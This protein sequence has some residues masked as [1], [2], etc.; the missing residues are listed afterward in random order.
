MA[1]NQKARNCLQGFD[2]APIRQKYSSRVPPSPI[3]RRVHNSHDLRNNHHD[4]ARNL[5]VQQMTVVSVYRRR[6]QPDTRA[7]RLMAILTLV[8]LSL[9][10]RVKANI[11]L[12]FS[13]SCAVLTDGSAKCWGSGSDGRLGRGG[14]TSSSFWS[15]STP[16]LVSELATVQSL[17]LGDF[18]SCAVLNDGSAKCWGKNSDGQL[19]D[20]TTTSSSTPVSV[21]GI[22][23]AVS[24][25]LGSYHSC[26]ILTDGSIKCWGKG[27]SLGGLLG[28]GATTSSSSPVSVSGI[29]TATSIALGDYFSC[30]VLTDGS[31]KCWG[32]NGYGQLGD[33]SSTHSSIPVSVSGI[34]TAT[35]ISLGSIH[36]CAVLTDR[37]IKCWGDNSDGRLGDGSTT[38][39]ATPVS[40]TGISTAVGVALGYSYSCAVLM[41]GSAKCWGTN[42]YGQ[43][44]D[45]STTGS[46]TPVSVTG[47]STASS[48]AL[49]SYHSCALLTDELAKCWGNND[50]GQLGDG[51]QTSSSTPVSVIDTCDA[52][53]APSNGGVGDCT[54]SLA[55]GSTCQ[56]T[57]NSGYTVSGTSSCSAG[58]LT[59]ATCAAT[60]VSTSASASYWNED[61]S[62]GSLKD[63][64]SITSSS[65]GTK[66]AAVGN[67][68]RIWTSTDFGE[69]W[70][71][72]SSMG[73][74]WW[75]SITSSSDG[76][77]LAA[78]ATSGYIYTSADSGA[79]WTR[80]TSVGG[81]KYW[82]GV[83]SSSDGTRLAAVAYL[84]NI[85]TSAD[86]GATWT[87]DA[88]VGSTKY[89]RD[90]AS[91]SDGTKLAAVVEGENIWTSADSGATW[92][93]DA[94]VGSTESWASIASS[95][96]GTKLA[97]VVSGGNIWTSTDSGATWIEDTSVGS[98]K[99]WRDIASSSDGTKLAAVVEGGSI[100]TYPTK[101]T[102][103]AALNSAY[104]SVGTDCTAVNG[105]C[106][107]SCLAALEALDAYCAGKTFTYNETQ[108]GV[109]LEI[110]LDWDTDRARWL[111]LYQTGINIGVFFGTNDA[112]NEVIHDYQLA[113]IND[114]NEA[115]HNA[116]TDVAH[117]YYCKE[118]MS[119]H[120]TC[121]E[122]CQETINKLDSVCNPVGGML[123]NYSTD[124]EGV[125][126]TTT[127]NFY[128]MSA[129]QSLGPDSCSIQFAR[130]PSPPP[131]P[132]EATL[133]PPPESAF[134]PE[135]TTSSS[136][137][138]SDT[139][140]PIINSCF[141]FAAACVAIIFAL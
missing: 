71:E 60:V 27:S 83:T 65:D 68:E 8:L 4:N 135:A 118:P 141:S 139:P 53:G 106:P 120:T 21:S 3:I 110:A 107:S 98:T 121:H 117:G 89:W 11:S 95:S 35:N 15:G 31:V 112:C 50:S 43:L 122:N 137:S 72:D 47:I 44:G 57:C 6:V 36:S 39:S 86:S 34:S 91:S 54:D 41:S 115:F 70:T 138:T 29:T 108:N 23:T 79:T 66:L 30:A 94:S 113:H 127:Y 16:V 88:S 26:A 62:V 67:A 28:N 63:W 131:P 85:W 75:R 123:G 104:D 80:D 17:A 103:D 109:D 13:H 61:T 132:Q 59:M 38:D 10:E 64:Y 69:T 82:W 134:E 25:A 48:I 111:I 37:S 19:G 125:F 56:P 12:G 22:S 14:S 74:Q 49:G 33:G 102:C 77:K 100:W 84:G 78:V 92:T 105:V 87:E 99:S 124:L 119:S 58:T 136:T 90:I 51:S 40:V 5:P 42:S 73:N 24:I 46:L 76:T 96:D 130:H 129:I 126:K 32:N 45:G 9:V 114:C 97:A 133:P 52:S 20:G 81:S 116:A 7:S 55:S 18:H 140:R 128:V 101:P 1:S 93:E 2:P